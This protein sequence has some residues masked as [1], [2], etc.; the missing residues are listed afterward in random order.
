MSF[1][2]SNTE[3][4]LYVVAINYVHFKIIVINIWARILK[5]FLWKNLNYLNYIFSIQIL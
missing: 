3:V 2:G 5:Y 4:V 1:M